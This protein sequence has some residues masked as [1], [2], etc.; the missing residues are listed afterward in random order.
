MKLLELIKV[1][2]ASH[3]S[4]IS[5]AMNGREGKQCRERWHNHLN[6]NIMKD[7]WTD[8]ED[9]RLYL[10]Y[11]LYGSKWSILAYMFPGR[12]DNSIK[13]HWNS[14]M[15]KKVKRFENFLKDI[16][17]KRI[18]PELTKLDGDL[19]E[20][21][22]RSEFDNK[23]CRKG[24]TRNYSYFFEKNKLQ[25][26]VCI[27]DKLEVT[28][29]ETL[30]MEMEES[31]M[32]QEMD[33][34]KEE[35]INLIKKEINHA[36]TERSGRKNPQKNIEHL[37]ELTPDSLLNKLRNESR[38]ETTINVQKQDQL[39]NE[40][41]KIS[42]FFISNFFNC[43]EK[44]IKHSPALN[45][46]LQSIYSQSNEKSRH[47]DFRNIITP[48][49]ESFEFSNGKYYDSKSSF[50]SQCLFSNFKSLD[51]SKSLDYS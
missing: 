45:M 20:R 19:I 38:M 46:A 25:E 29:Q 35:S 31:E 7:S 10:L 9:L 23:T 48:I 11:R 5:F 47:A 4:T 15:K 49:K 51:I 41:E 17:E 18:F 8:K 21:I 14:I 28:G 12:T 37:G 22:K 42:P 3:W 40:N 1:Y 16:I 36:F 34:E 33:M 32:K 24:R 43:Y 44:S 26:Y 6:P 39:I 50:K 13:N 27:K 2:G 30:Y